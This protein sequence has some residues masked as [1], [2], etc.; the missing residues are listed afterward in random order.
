MASSWVSL[1]FA[2]FPLATVSFGYRKKKTSFGYR[3][4]EGQET[5]EGK[6]RRVTISTK[7]DGKASQE[8][9]NGQRKCTVLGSIDAVPSFS[10]QSSQCNESRV[11]LLK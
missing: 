9:R 11:E 5:N 6:K 4:K 3:K 8:E 2:Q 7:T 1:G 10:S